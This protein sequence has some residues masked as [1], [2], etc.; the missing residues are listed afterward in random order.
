M[1]GGGTRRGRKIWEGGRGSKVVRKPGLGEE[2]E[3]RESA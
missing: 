2:G 1:V 3:K